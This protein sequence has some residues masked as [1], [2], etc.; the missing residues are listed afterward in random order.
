M[1]WAR[2]G[3]NTVAA[4]EERVKC[5]AYTAFAEFLQ[6]REDKGVTL[7]PSTYVVK[8]IFPTGKVKDVHVYTLITKRPA[9]AYTRQG[10]YTITAT[11][12]VGARFALP[13]GQAVNLANAFSMPGE[14]VT[15]PIGEIQT[16]V[17]STS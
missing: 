8:K 4:T 17:D 5:S 1:M 10:S 12:T 14:P 7:Q 16:R 2:N 11:S 9:Y 13:D 6:D 15:L 3:Q